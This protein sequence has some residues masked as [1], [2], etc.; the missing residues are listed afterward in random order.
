MRF[1]LVA[2][3]AGCLAT[4]AIAEPPVARPLARNTPESQGIASSA[5]LDFVE[6]ADREIQVM[7]SFMLIRHGQ[8]VAEGWWAPYDAETPHELY[9]LSKSFTSTAVGMAIA[10]GK[11]SLDDEVWK[12]FPDDAPAERSRNLQSM[13]VRDLLTMSTGHESEPR[14]SGSDQPWTKTFLAHAVPHKPGA[15]FMYNT[16][17]TF[18]LSA[19][20]QKQTGLTV[21]DYLKPRLFEPLGIDNAS[22]G[23]NP[24]GIT[25][26]GYG[27]SVRTE[28]IA[29]FGQLYLQKGDWNGQQLL[30]REWIEVA[31]SKQTSN[32]SNPQSDWD[33]GY[34]FQFWRSRNGCYRGDGAFGQY[35]LVMPEQDAVLAITSGV[36]D[37]QAV[38]NLVWD[39][40]VPALK[41]APL[42][43][44]S[45]AADH[46]RARLLQL[47]VPVVVGR[48]SSPIGSEVTDKQFQFAANPQKVESLGIHCQDGTDQ[49]TLQLRNQGR[50]Q[51]IECRSSGWTKGR[52]AWGQFA[53]QPIAACGA[54]TDK[55]TYTAKLCFPETPYTLTLRLKFNQQQLLLDSELNV[56]FGPTSQPQ[57]T[58]ELKLPQ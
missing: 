4:D 24:Q 21:W 57:L 36:K 13:R 29:R 41:S 55:Q 32:G 17:A 38:L 39:K 11:L 50:E 1:L 47:A 45:A 58:G 9:S 54:W 6:S 40:L 43:A 19:I 44:D 31:T 42:P 46:L 14:L 18:M 8:V 10:E 33:Q 5:L 7:N 53:D 48:P 51:R 3:M 37:M 12:F 2:F 56:S 27:L 26:G 16:P 20:V 49:V 34:G 35:C 22:W 30:P 28:D 52:L 25:L 23:Q 15:H